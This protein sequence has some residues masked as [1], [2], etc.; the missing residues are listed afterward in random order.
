[1]KY[2]F[3]ILLFVFLFKVCN[4]QVLKFRSYSSSIKTNGNYGWT[5]WSEPTENNILIVLD[6]DKNRVSIYSKE[7]Q[8][9]DIYKS[10]DRVTDNDG[11]YIF[12]YACIDGE[13]LR[14]HIRWVKL[15]S[16]NGRIQV[17]VDFSDMMWMYNVNLLE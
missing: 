16:Q 2:F 8:V 5:K 13:G 9:Y 10:Y 17:Y 15:N 1:M 6:L 12:E 14:C 11:D 3:S 4:A 7:T